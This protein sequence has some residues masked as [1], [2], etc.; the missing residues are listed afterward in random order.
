MTMTDSEKK[1]HALQI[2]MP[3]A[4]PL[5]FEKINVELQIK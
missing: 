1:G 3:M 2:V 5:T 4:K